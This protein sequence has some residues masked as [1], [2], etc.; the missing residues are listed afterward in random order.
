MNT[1]C[2]DG[3]DN[4]Y[5]LGISVS[6]M[7]VFNQHFINKNPNLRSKKRFNA[8]SLSQ[9]KRP[10]ALLFNFISHISLYHDACMDMCTC[11]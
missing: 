4:R 5:S 10:P 3:L 7:R 2:D 11:T 6:E 8:Y 9:Y 1:G